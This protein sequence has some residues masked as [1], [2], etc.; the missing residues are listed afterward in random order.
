MAK[1]QLAVKPRARRV[2]GSIPGQSEKKRRTNTSWKHTLTPYLWL[3]PALLLY[4]IFKIYPL[5]EGLWLSLL[6]WDGID[7]P[8]FIGLRNFQRMFSDDQLG[9]A[10][11]HNVEYALASVIG[12]VVLSLFLAVLINQQLRG[13]G[14]YRT[15]LFTPVVMSFVV[16]ALLWTWLYNYQFGLVN[17]LLRILGLGFLEQ[18][19]LGN[20]NLAL[21]S[22][23]VVDI[24]KWYGFHMVI[25]LSGLQTISVELYE[26]ARVDGATPWQ[27][28]LHITLPLL[29][30]VMIINITIALAGAFNTFD[31]PFLM[32]GG[33]PGNATLVLS[34]HIYQQAFQFNKLGYGSALSYA[35]FVLVSIVVLLQLKFMMPTRRSPGGNG[36]S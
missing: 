28:F 24:W 27:R 20:P 13:R 17:N 11:L 34:L 21:W 10:L 12:K 6:N 23:V 16:I 26:A 22:E 2:Q 7:D 29:Q 8:V 25:F 5:I 3:A 33:G 1:T 30:P 36:E 15:A 4:G 31:I 18:D 14:I 32:T 35:L 9:V 19:W